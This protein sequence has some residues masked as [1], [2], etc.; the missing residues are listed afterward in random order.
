[1]SDQIHCDNDVR[2]IRVTLA[3]DRFSVWK[4]RDFHHQDL[5]TQIRLESDGRV[6]LS[7]QEGEIHTLKSKTITFEQ[8]HAAIRN[9]IINQTP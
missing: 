8:L 6:Y 2:D 9:I 1:M 5:H 7:S 3:H 4:G